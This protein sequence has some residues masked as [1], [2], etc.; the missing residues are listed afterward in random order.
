MRL[1]GWTTEV[2]QVQATNNLVYVTDALRSA[3]SEWTLTSGLTWEEAALVQP[4]YGLVA[5]N[6]IGNYGPGELSFIKDGLKYQNFQ[7]TAFNYTIDDSGS[8]FTFHQLLDFSPSGGYFTPIS[9]PLPS[10]SSVG[11]NAGS[12]LITTPFFFDMLDPPGNRWLLLGGVTSLSFGNP[13]PCYLLGGQSQPNTIQRITLTFD[14]STID[15][16]TFIDQVGEYSNPS[17]GGFNASGFSNYQGQYE[18]T[19][20]VKH[21]GST[22]ATTNFQEQPGG[23]WAVQN[24]SAS[25]TSKTNSLSVTSTVWLYNGATIDS[26][27]L[28]FNLVPE[29]PS[30]LI[31]MLGLVG[32]SYRR[33]LWRRS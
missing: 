27:V 8:G 14:V 11:F 26:F 33:S 4:G 1:S 18:I 10:S 7:L 28:G 20:T 21:L 2:A 23:T 32:L 15:P 31:A 17:Y 12:N 3:V 6:Q 5:T 22:Y 13:C 24:A 30:G 9:G 19:T 29:P 16:N 25:L